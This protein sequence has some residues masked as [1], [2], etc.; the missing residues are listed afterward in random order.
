[1]SLTSHSIIGQ[2]GN[3]AKIHRWTFLSQ[4][5][6]GFREGSLVYG[7]DMDVANAMQRTPGSDAPIAL[8]SGVFPPT[9]CR[10]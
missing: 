2:V 9:S 5:A 7:F 10:Y 8:P 1:M 4:D 3:Y 6:T